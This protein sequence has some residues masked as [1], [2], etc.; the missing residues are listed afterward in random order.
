MGW[1]KWGED[2]GSGRYLQGLKPVA[3]LV[4]VHKY[5]CQLIWVRSYRHSDLPAT[6]TDVDAP[7]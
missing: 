5:V 2:G 4:P 1:G 3:Q 7:R 6:L